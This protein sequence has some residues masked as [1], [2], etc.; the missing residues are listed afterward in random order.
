M[1]DNDWRIK[2]HPKDVIF[3]ILDSKALSYESQIANIHR[4]KG[5]SINYLNK[6]R[7]PC[8][9]LLLYYTN[10][11]TMVQSTIHIRT[12]APTETRYAEEGCNVINGAYRSGGLYYSDLVSA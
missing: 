2:L 6:S 5:F 10:L 11:S 8:F 9:S 7:S 1:L 4:T 12:I 3:C